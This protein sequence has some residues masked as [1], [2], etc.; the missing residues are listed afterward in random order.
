M[1]IDIDRAVIASDGEIVGKVTEVVYDL[2]S[3]E[4]THIVVAVDMGIQRTVV[5]PISEVTHADHVG[6]F[7]TLTADELQRMPDYLER[8]LGPP[9]TEWEA[10]EGYR[11]QDRQFPVSGYPAPLGS[12]SYAPRPVRERRNIPEGSIEIREGMPVD[13]DDGHVGEVDRVSM[14]TRTPSPRSSSG[15]AWSCRKTS[16]FPS[17]GPT[18]STVNA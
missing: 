8:D 12:T 14:S 6:V 13:C 18:R 5:V 2:D 4:A 1:D 10:P 7:V 9:G 3:N 15:A 17:N 11:P 16:R